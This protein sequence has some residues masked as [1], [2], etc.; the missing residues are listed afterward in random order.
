MAIHIYKRNE[1]YKAKIPISTNGI[2]SILNHTGTLD[3]QKA[4]SPKYQSHE[5]LANR[6]PFVRTTN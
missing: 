3:K 5:E 6:A 1:L 2:F 4:Q